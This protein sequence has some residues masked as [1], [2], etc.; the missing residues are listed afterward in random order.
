M[1]G[2]VHNSDRRALRDVRRVAAGLWLAA[3]TGVLAAAAGCADPAALRM[4]PG[5][6][7]GKVYYLDGVGCY[8]FGRESVPSG[9]RE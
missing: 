8:G 2:D 5:E 1:T 9:L 6:T 4:N 7:H 3:A